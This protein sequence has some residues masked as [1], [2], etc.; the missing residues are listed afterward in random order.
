MERTPRQIAVLAG[1]GGVIAGFAL[2]FFAGR[3]HLRSELR[4]SIASAFGG[5]GIASTPAKPG[6]ADKPKKQPNTTNFKN[7]DW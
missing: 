3:E 4:Q 1:A 7:Q 2:G 5:S 6:N